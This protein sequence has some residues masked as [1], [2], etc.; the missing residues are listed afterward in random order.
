MNSDKISIL[1]ICK[2]ALKTERIKIILSSLAKLL[3]AYIVI[4]KQISL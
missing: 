3:I 2:Y 1:V 4:Y